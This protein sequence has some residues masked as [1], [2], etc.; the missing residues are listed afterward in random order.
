MKHSTRLP[1]DTTQTS[2]LGCQY[3]IIYWIQVIFETIWCSLCVDAFAFFSSFLFFLNRRTALT[4]IDKHHVRLRV[5]D[6]PTT[7]IFL[8]ASFMFL[9]LCNFAVCTVSLSFVCWVSFYV[10]SQTNEW[11]VIDIANAT[12]ITYALLPRT[13]HMICFWLSF[14]LHQ[15][16]ITTNASTQCLNM[17]HLA[18]GI[19]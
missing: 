6:G 18:P 19:V 10:L 14:C 3:I 17:M 15:L 16:Q 11:N 13:C 9:L 12:A 5:C 8:V 2:L 4:H 7:N 1:F